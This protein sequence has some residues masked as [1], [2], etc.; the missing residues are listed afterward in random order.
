MNQQEQKIQFKIEG[1]TC[2]NCALSVTKYLEKNEAHAVNVDFGTGEVNFKIQS[3]STDDL[4]GNIK[5]GI[6]KL[7]YSVKELHDHDDH[8]PWFDIKKKFL[9]SAIITL[10]LFC[11]MFF[12]FSFLED[13]YVQLVICIPVMIIGILHFGR[14]AWASIKMGVPNM[15]V[16]IFV[17]S[18]SAFIYSLIG[19]VQN[20]GSGYLF[21]ETAATI[22]TL[23]LLGNLIEH[24][25]VK[26]TSSAIQD[27]G[28]LQTKIAKKVI[29]E[30]DQ[31][32]VIE[33]NYAD[34]KQ[35][36]I[37]LANSGDNI[38]VDG[39]IVWGNGSV[40]ESM[41]TG[42]SVPVDKYIT[43]DVIG[44]TVLKY[45]NIKMI[46]KKVGSETVLAQIIDL[47]KNAQ[48][49]K[50]QIQKL[51]DK[52]SAIFVPVVLSI[53][54]ITFCVTY[55]FLDIDL[56]E[57]LM[58]AVAVLVI[59][60][61]CAMGLATPTAVAAGIGKAAKRGI[62]IKGGST[63][64]EFASVKNI[65]F[66]KTG[67]LTT[68]KF[69]I[70]KIECFGGITEQELLTVVYSLELFSSHPI[71]KSLIDILVKDGYAPIYFMETKEEKGIGIKAV[72]KE[73]NSYQIGSY[74]IAAHLT[75]D[76]QHDIYII[77]N[78][79]LVG[80]IDIGDE[81]KNGAQE[82]I[83]RL[84]K[85]NYQ[86]ILL[87]GDRIS[88]CNA[89]AE[90]IGI[91]KIYSEQLPDQKL[92]RIDELIAKAP[93]AMVGDG[94]N[95]APALAKATVG[96]SLSNAS[97]IAVQSAQVILLKGRLSMLP[98]ALQISKLTL[99][100]IKQNL[101]WAFFYNVVAIPLAAMGML[102]PMVAALTMAFSD[103]IVIGNSIRLKYR[104]ID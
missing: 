84:G 36:D 52:V 9:V 23:V 47:V 70:Q 73:N 86:S 85:N 88:K 62:L 67:T 39:T 29:T 65:V 69:Q 51:G 53:A 87:S 74:K 59:S 79:A 48:A 7:G 13:P 16:L 100:T 32:K 30:N 71:A 19:T 40:D 93:T 5:N 72:D 2:S 103:V 18:S 99:Q 33:V 96:V 28:N 31:E 57:S 83:E 101:F 21:Y 54:I 66:D 95:D 25:T 44:G 27:L 77:K 50:P 4:V 58:R 81:I 24:T 64:E 61:P 76:K 20:L 91:N 1:M 90:Q 11:Q 63:L 68:G 97:D 75:K 104:K 26:K 80:Q 55:F 12:H 89:V 45:G 102:N 22:I 82:M 6:N 43:D 10:P 17:G 56:Q 34:I 8:G 35:E 49:S 14:S 46:A 41:L 60:C 38:P 3:E 94:I 42:E 37:L 15:D 92:N 78:D 98:K